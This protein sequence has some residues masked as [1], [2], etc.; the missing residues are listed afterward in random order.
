MRLMKIVF[1][2]IYGFVLFLILLFATL[3]IDSSL[4]FLQKIG[5]NVSLSDLPR[6]LSRFFFIIASIM[7]MAPILEHFRR[8]A[9]KDKLKKS[10]Q[11]V[12]SIKRKIA[13]RRKEKS[14]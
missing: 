5:L 13:S 2:T 9:F 1:Y 3:K 10:E 4:R 11:L 7:I 8:K 6:I 14:H 12:N